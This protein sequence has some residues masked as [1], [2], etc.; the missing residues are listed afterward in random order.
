LIA[1]SAGRRG[2]PLTHVADRHA[3]SFTRKRAVVP[4]E[5][6]ALLSHE[7]D[8]V[9]LEPPSRVEPYTLAGIPVNDQ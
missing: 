6:Q 5:R 9:E 1:M 3:V 2:A 8:D 4:L 7:P